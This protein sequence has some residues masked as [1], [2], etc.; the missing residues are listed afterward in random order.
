MAWFPLGNTV[1]QYVD[2]NGDPYSGAVLKFYENGTST[3][4]DVATDSTG[5]TTVSS[6]ALNASG[7]PVV[8][9]NVIIPHVDQEFKVSLYPTQ[10]AADSNTGAIWTVDNVDP[11]SELTLAATLTAI[12]NLAVTDGNIIVGNGTTWVVESGNTARTSLGVGTGDSPTFTGLTLSGLTEGHTLVVGA[13][14]LEGVN[15]L[16]KGNIIVG[17]GTS[18]PTALPVGSNDQILTADST[19]ASGVKW[20]A[21]P[22]A[23]SGFKYSLILS[24]NST[25]SDHD[26]DVTTGSC[27]DSTNSV[28]LTLASAFTKRIDAT[29][30]SGTGNGGLA[31]GAT[32]ANTTWYHVF[33][34]RVGGSDDVMFDTSVTCANGVANNAV[35][36]FRR[37]G[38]VLT[39][40]S[41]NIIAFVQVGDV[42][43]WAVPVSDVAGINP[44]TSAVTSTLTVP[45][46]VRVESHISILLGP[47]TSG[48]ALFALVTSPDQTDSTPSSTLFSA[49]CTSTNSTSGSSLRVITN[50][51]A[52]IRYR[53]GSSSNGERV[54]ITT[55]GWREFF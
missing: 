24:N 52:Q 14:G 45:T 39:D 33:I 28:T 41:A 7:Y 26:I 4:L 32:L 50:S 54:N 23:A 40:G 5:G 38:A 44:G 42:F 34:V 10:A 48:A 21:A 2:A 43:R 19:Q 9:G 11:Q 46:N 1:T 55:H 20:G 53:I 47:G 12:S 27:S 49:A 30:A 25:D 31:S 29:W 15:T 51:S 22:A 35:T 8:S 36:H 3:V 37:I 18:V 6:V 17:D 13:S 16:T